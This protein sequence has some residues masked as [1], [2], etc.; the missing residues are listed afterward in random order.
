MYEA[1]RQDIWRQQDQ[2]LLASLQPFQNLEQLLR[3]EFQ[4]FIK[5]QLILHLLSEKGE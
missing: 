3:S 2:Y 5:I 4:K 1:H